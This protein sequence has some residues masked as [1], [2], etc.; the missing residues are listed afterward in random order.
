M[1]EMHVT[2]PPLWASRLV[3]KVRTLADHDPRAHI[4]DYLIRTA[5]M[6]HSTR[7]DLFLRTCCM[8]TCERMRHVL[9]S[10]VSSTVQWVSSDDAPVGSVY[11]VDFDGEHEL[12]IVHEWVFQSFA[13]QHG[14]E[15]RPYNPHVPIY[16]HISHGGAELAYAPLTF[17]APTE[18]I[19]LEHIA[20]ST[21]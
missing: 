7:Q 18:P 9:S 14:I 19:L 5:H 10:T 20:N 11:S 6:I 1:S 17:Y 15:C 21:S 12:V 8:A 16:T 2:T 13:F 4:S 3:E